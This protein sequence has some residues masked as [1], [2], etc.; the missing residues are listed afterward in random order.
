MGLF[1]WNNRLL[2]THQLLDE[3]TIAFT[4]SE[5]P[6]VAWVSVISQWYQ[7]CNPTS[8]I[9]ISK[10]IFHTAWFSYSSLLQLEGDMI[11]PDCGPSPEAVIFDG[12]SLSFNRKH[13]LT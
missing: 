3:Y 9:F 6:F 13:M 11:C 2:F 7:S 5:T 1:N 12:V 4:S 10:K 8:T